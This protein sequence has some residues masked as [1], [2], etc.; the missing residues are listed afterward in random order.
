[1]S[2]LRREEVTRQESV[3]RLVDEELQSLGLKAAQRRPEF[4]FLHVY[5]FGEK[6]D[7]WIVSF[8]HGKAN[9]VGSSILEELQRLIDVLEGPSAP[10]CLI[11]LS[12]R[13]SQ[14]G[15]AIF[16]SGAN[17][18]EREGWSDERVKAHVRHQRSLL[19]RLRDAPVFHIC[20]INGVALGWGTEYLITADYKLVGPEAGFALPETGLGILPGAGGTSELPSL[21]GLAHTLRLGMT[22]EL[23][24]ANEA[25]RIGLAQEECTDLQTGVERALNLAS[26]AIKR[27]PTAIAAFKRAALGSIGLNQEERREAEAQA[28][29]HCVE[30]GQAAIGRR[31]FALIRAGETPDWGPRQS[32]L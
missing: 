7:I 2:D 21:I 24:S 8:H 6:N 32:T 5:E 12:T 23:I 29:E 27:S 18:T 19:G 15:K 13:R 31:D 4:N 1:M 20:L 3:Q 25:I 26:L 16:I 10:I 9:E 28:Y 17:V 30:S 22:G 11:S 14:R